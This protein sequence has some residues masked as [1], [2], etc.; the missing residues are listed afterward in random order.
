[1]FILSWNI[2]VGKEFFRIYDHDYHI[3]EIDENIKSVCQRFPDSGMTKEEIA[4]M[5]DVPF[6]FVNSCIR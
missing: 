2:A 3:I 1:M 6:K 4:K 5:M